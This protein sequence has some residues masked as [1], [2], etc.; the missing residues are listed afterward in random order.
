[1]RRIALFLALILPVV[2]EAN[3]EAEHWL[4]KM[5]AAVDSLNYEGTMI[6][7][8][9]NHVET[10][11][12]LHGSDQRGVKE[13]LVSLT[14]EAREVIRNQDVLTCIWPGSRYIMVARGRTRTGIP[15]RLPGEVDRL[16]EHY[17]LVIS[18]TDR[19]AGLACK[20]IEINPKDDFRY[21]YRFC[22]DEQSGILLKSV[23][24][25]P[26]SH[27]VE[28]VMFTDLRLLDHI[29]DTQFEPHVAD[30]GYTWHTVTARDQKS[31]RRP[32]LAWRIDRM[33]AGFQISENV[34]RRI[35]ANPQPVQHI[36]LS[37]GLASVSVFIDNSEIGNE[38][39][40]TGLTGKGS[41]H[42]YS[43]NVN[44]HHVTVVGEVPEVTV[45]LIAQ[46]IVYQQGSHD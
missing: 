9:D 23:M 30:E 2:G 42:A 21:G 5:T 6:L 12:V 19:I 38:A 29:P 24:L 7:I 22:I 17:D 28:Q 18:G 13:R 35:A 14:G 45:K 34:K 4:K 16:S 41:M 8:H 25:G 11:H 44:S 39:F 1:M 33:P 46:S 20:M 10:M 27:P 26:E 40:F 3:Q 43:R 37:D 32:D 31:M 36:I 15:T